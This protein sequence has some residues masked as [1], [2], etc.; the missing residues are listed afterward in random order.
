[1]NAFHMIDRDWIAEPLYR[2]KPWA[3]IA[4]GLSSAILDKPLAYIPAAALVC[5]GGLILAWRR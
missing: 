1:M 2:A 3:L 4:A 5:A